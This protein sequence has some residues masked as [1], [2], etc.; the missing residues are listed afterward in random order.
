MEKW[1]K[2]DPEHI[3]SLR[4]LDKFMVNHRGFIAGGC[5]KNLFNGEHIK[6]IDVF[7][8]DNADFR[9]GV[10]SLNRCEEFE[11]LYTSENVNAYRHKQSGV[12][13]ELV[14]SIFGTPE[15]IISQFDFTVTKFAYYKEL[16]KKDGEVDPFELEDETD[17]DESVW[18]YK[19]VYHPQ[20]FEHLHLKRLIIDDLIP[21]PMS[22]FNRVL[23]YRKYGFVPCVE[24]KQKLIDTLRVLPEDEVRVPRNFYEGF[25]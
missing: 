24:T 17:A 8:L 14:R 20:F 15:E 4:Q 12:T 19:A 25:D 6:D 16:I 22:T 9:H 11:H 13:V 1:T 23:R 2:S 5:F 21:F 10:E 7:F 3:F 18:E